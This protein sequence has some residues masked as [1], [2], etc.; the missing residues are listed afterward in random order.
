[1]SAKGEYTDAGCTNKV[2]KGHGGTYE[3]RGALSIAEPE[4]TAVGGEA[5]V[6]ESVRG[7]KLV[8]T[9]EESESLVTAQLASPQLRIPTPWE[10]ILR[11]IA[12][13]LKKMILARGGPKQI[14]SGSFSFAEGEDV[15]SGARCEPTTSTELRGVLGYIS[16]GGSPDPSVGLM[17]EAPGSSVFAE[18]PCP[19]AGR[20][21]A[22]IGRKPHAKHRDGVISRITP[23]DE[24]T[25]TF[26][27]T[28]S[29]SAPGIQ[30]PTHFEG[31]RLELLEATG[32]G[33]G[34]A[35]EQTALT[36]EAIDTS[37]EPL[38]IRA[39]CNGC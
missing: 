4:L 20:P 15:G 6:F 28:F 21:S 18:F 19:A 29:E 33:L 3:W 9:T 35:F 39:Y 37:K 23:I 10:I 14:I 1:V 25:T 7:N 22:V 24:M 16:G 11:A 34:G 38:E 26:S 27:E 30:D 13:W 32:E 17:Y 5:L 36:A 2:G 12:R 8:Y 31:G